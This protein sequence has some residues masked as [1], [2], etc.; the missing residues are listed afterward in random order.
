[1]SDIANSDA[2]QLSRLVDPEGNRT[3]GVLTKLDLMDE[4]TNAFDILTNKTLPL[5]HGY[6]GVVNRSQKE[7]DQNTKVTSALQKEAEWFR[8]HPVYGTIH[9]QCGTAFL[10]QKLRQVHKHFQV[11]LNFM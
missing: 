11:V 2:L 3:V 5:R 7:I 4:G 9:K 6:V 8:Q 1:M 10:Q